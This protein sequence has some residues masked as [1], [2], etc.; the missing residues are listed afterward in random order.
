M[1]QTLW[2]RHCNTKCKN[3]KILPPHKGVTYYCYQ[4]NGSAVTLQACFWRCLVQTWA[5]SWKFSWLS[6]VS[7]C[8]LNLFQ[9]INYNTAEHYSQLVTAS[10]NKP[11][12]TTTK[13]LVSRS[14]HE[15][16]ALTIT[17]P[18]SD[19]YLLYLVSK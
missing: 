12:A 14:E 7:L 9:V 11:Q 19:W 18:H 4:C 2:A 16:G 15:A 17:K 5:V 1:S 10:S 13:E 3:I 6:S 8:K